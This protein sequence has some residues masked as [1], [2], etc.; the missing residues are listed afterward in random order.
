MSWGLARGLLRPCCLGRN[1]LLACCRVNNDIAGHTRTCA[2]TRAPAGDP[3]A[4]L[5]VISRTLP[6]VPGRRY[7]LCLESLKAVGIEVRIAR[8][9]GGAK[10]ARRRSDEFD[11]A[12]GGW[13]GRP[14][15][16]GNMYSH[17]ITEGMNNL[18]KYSNPRL[19]ALL[20][21]ARVSPDMSERKRLYNEASQLIAQDAPVVFL[22]HPSWQKG[23]R[24]SV[25]GYREIP[26]GRR[27]F[28]PV[29]SK[30]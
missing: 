13:S 12:T 30:G 6:R 28:E 24:T 4:D 7:L 5:A 17:F 29:W 25:A 26:D 10:L 15:P 8:M 1:L 19:D 23:W 22:R 14:D 27:R 21:Q 3:E 16:D 11:A 20:K 9:E 2:V 18:S